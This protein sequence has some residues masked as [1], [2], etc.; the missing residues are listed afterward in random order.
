MEEL[1]K[2]LDNATISLVEA[3]DQKEKFKVEGS[4]VR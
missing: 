4:Q 3:E 2:A 1:S